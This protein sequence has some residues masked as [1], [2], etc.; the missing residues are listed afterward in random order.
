MTP[1]QPSDLELQVLGVLWRRG[2]STVREVLEAMPDGKERAYTTVLSVMQVMEKKELVGHTA[3]GRTHV[4]RPKVGKAEVFR[5]LLKDF[6]A[7][8]FGGSTAA[9]VQQFLQQTD[10]S[11][12]ELDEIRRLLDRYDGRNEKRER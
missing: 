8:V 7:N 5:P 3:R 4:Y 12:E 9:A 6:V 2:P 11:D 1:A 10:V